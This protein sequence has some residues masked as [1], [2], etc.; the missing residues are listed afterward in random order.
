MG[1]KRYTPTPCTI[2][3]LPDIDIVCISHNHYDHL[4][5]ATV[6]E[7]K[8]KHGDQIRFFAP[9]G[10]REWLLRN[11][12]CGPHEAIESD[13][14][15]SH[16]IHIPGRGSV[17]LTCC[18]AQHNSGRGVSDHGATLWSSWALEAIPPQSPSPSSSSSSSP[19]PNKPPRGKS[20]FFAGDTAYQSPTSPAPCPAFAQIGTL[21][22][23]FDLALLPIGLC[24]PARFMGS[25][26]ATPEQSFEIHKA[27]GARLSLGM[28][29]GTV[30]GGISAHYEDVRDPPRRW[31]IV[32]EEAGAWAGGGRG[33]DEGGGEGG[34]GGWV[35]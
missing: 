23:P 26:H 7:L 33:G 3:E 19:S 1:P 29:Y 12:P 25:F 34:A 10:N 2:A 14:W 30:R 24:T 27:V 16:L 35:V 15:Q 13:W 17:K 9:L 28:H 5:I 20:L 21:L 6:K 18:P 4:D 8:Q 31:R 22:G 11:V 32:G